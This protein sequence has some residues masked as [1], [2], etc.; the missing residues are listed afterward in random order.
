MLVEPDKDDVVVMSGNK[1]K[2]Q[3]STIKHYNDAMVTKQVE[4]LVDSGSDVQQVT[5]VMLLSCY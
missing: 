4:E 5:A 3:K 1:M 2:Q